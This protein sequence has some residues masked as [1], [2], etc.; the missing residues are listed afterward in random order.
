VS[1]RLIP[2]EW[3]DEPR[4]PFAVTRRARARAA[5]GRRHGPLVRLWS[6]DFRLM[7]TEPARPEPLLR[8]FVRAPRRLIYAVR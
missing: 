6:E 3:L 4:G 1:L 7:H 2:R 5:L 8:W